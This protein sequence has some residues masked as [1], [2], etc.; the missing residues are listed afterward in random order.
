MKL[1]IVLLLALSSN[2]F[3]VTGKVKVG[4]V[5]PISGAIATFGQENANGIKLA[6]S[7]LKTKNIEL[8]IEDDKSEAIEATNAIRKLI[9]VDKVS[10]VIGEVTSS[11]T[12]AMDQLLK[13][14]KSRYFLQQ[15]LTRKSPW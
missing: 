11:N 10:I 7:K 9:N 8:I 14:Q 12:L 6:L 4:A 2:S 13:Q 1:L 3:A 15:Q 5:L